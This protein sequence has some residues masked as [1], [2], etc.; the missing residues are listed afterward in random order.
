[1]KKQLFKTAILLLTLAVL[2]P[3]SSFAFGGGK[4]RQQGPPPEAIAACEGKNVGDS[5]E[6]TGPR[7]ESLEG[8][9]QEIDGQLAAAPDDMPEGGGRR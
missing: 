9:C 3:T 5:V 2:I 8:T 7:G 1:M 4:G 6:F